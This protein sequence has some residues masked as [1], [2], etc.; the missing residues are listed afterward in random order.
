MPDVLFCL[1][2]RVQTLMNDVPMPKRRPIAIA[3][4]DLFPRVWKGRLRRMDGAGMK[5]GDVGEHRP[6]GGLAETGDFEFEGGEI[7]DHGMSVV[8]NWLLA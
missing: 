8:R 1:R 5:V 3:G 6:P 7:G 4:A 2:E